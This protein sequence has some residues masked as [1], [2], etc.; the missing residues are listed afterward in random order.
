M[1]DIIEN[2]T[3][4]VI[5]V[6]KLGIKPNIILINNH[7]LNKVKTESLNP[8]YQDRGY[9]MPNQKGGLDIYIME[10]KLIISDIESPEVGVSFIKSL[11]E[12]II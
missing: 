12:V 9:L 4:M 6:R 11:E 8:K 10:C 3:D 1:K 2:I 7:D 5:K